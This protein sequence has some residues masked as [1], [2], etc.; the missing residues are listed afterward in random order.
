G[1]IAGAT[2]P[3]EESSAR[4]QMWKA[5]NHMVMSWLLNS[6]T[7][8]MGENIMYHQTAK[9]IWDATR[10]TYSNN[11][12]PS[13]IFEIKRVLHDLRQGEMTITDYFN[14]LIRYWQHL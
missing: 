3:L 2:V 5:E 9:E 4:Y 12:N 7:N 10:E 8:E 13:A 1:Y 6:I 11:D 14:A